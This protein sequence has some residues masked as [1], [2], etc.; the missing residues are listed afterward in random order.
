MTQFTGSSHVA[1]LLSVKTKGKVKIEDAGFDWKILG[2]DVPSPSEVDYVAWQCD[3][4]AYAASGQKC[5]AQ[6]ILFMHSNWV[7][8]GLLDKI[9][10]LAAERNLKKLTVGPV[11]TQTTD[12]ILGHVERLLKIPG[13]YTLFG[14]K[15]LPNH[16]IPTIYGAVEPT[17]VF[18]P[19]EAMLSDDK[20]FQTCTSEIFGPFQI[21]TEYDDKS[22]DLVLNACERMDNHLT[23]ALVSNDV[24]FQHKV[25]ANTVN[26]T[27]Y[28]GMRARTTGAPQNHWFGPSGD[29]RGAGIGTPEAIRQ[30]WS[31][32]REIIEDYLVPKM[33]TKPKQT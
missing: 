8:T 26:G 5:S 32:H 23:A 20:I 9:S 10:A 28:S 22:I 27:T 21:V 33:W 29:P 6:S 30:V 15:E 1:D 18:V 11:L 14:G 3:Q 24:A 2:P 12:S 4:D 31:S 7:K 17:A 13:S 19:I 25:L 16:S